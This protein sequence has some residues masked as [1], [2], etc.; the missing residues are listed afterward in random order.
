LRQ[1]AI[2]REKKKKKPG[3]TFGETKKKE[4]PKAAA[5]I[6]SEGTKGKKS[7]GGAGGVQRGGRGKRKE[8][9]ASL[10]KTALKKGRKG[11]IKVLSLLEGKREGKLLLPGAH[12]S[13]LS[14]KKRRR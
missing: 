6:S 3:Q 13:I 14:K 8:C 5:L 4:N 11:L 7:R 12:S 10:R 1:R 2:L 9:L